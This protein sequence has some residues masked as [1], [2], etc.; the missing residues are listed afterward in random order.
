MNEII[1]RAEIEKVT[2]NFAQVWVHARFYSFLFIFSEK[3]HI[4]IFASRE[5]DSVRYR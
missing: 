2:E 3:S 1:R 5:N 4:F